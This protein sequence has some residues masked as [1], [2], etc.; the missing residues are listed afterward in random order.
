[1]PVPRVLVYIIYQVLLLKHRA[2]QTVIVLP[3]HICWQSGSDATERIE[4]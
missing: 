3:I 1:M 4:E 2:Y